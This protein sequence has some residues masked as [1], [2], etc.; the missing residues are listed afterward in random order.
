MIRNL[1]GGNLCEFICVINV[2]SF[3]SRLLF[4]TFCVVYNKLDIGF[5]LKGESYFSIVL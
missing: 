1:I 2:Q 4:F 5:F 3:D